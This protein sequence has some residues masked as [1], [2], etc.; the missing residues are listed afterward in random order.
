MGRVLERAAVPERLM[1][2]LVVV[3]LHPVPD[4]PSRFVERLKD[5]L[6]DTL[7][8]E[9]AK[10]PFNDPVLFRRI[11]ELPPFVTPRPTKLTPA[12]PGT[13]CDDCE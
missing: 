1:R 13:G 12:L 7:F 10:E 2:L 9:T 3:P 4:D 5:V 11:G 6:P 8:F